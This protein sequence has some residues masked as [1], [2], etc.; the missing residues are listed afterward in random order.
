MSQILSCIIYH[1][2]ESDHITRI[3]KPYGG[4]EKME[5]VKLKLSVVGIGNGGCQVCSHLAKNGHRVFCINSSQKDLDE[6]ILAKNIPSYL[7]GDK[8]GAGRNR[9]T[10]KEF[11][12]I[13]LNKLFSNSVFTNLTDDADIIVVI[14]SM[15]GG[16]GSGTGPL[17]VNRIQ[18]MY[19]NK[20]V[21][22]FGILPKHSES[23][24][25]QFNALDCMKEVSNEKYPMTYMLADLSN[26][27]DCASDEAYQKIAAYA[28]DCMNVLRGDYNSE[29][30]YG[31]IDENDMLTI[32]AETGYMMINRVSNISQKELDKRSIQSMMIDK[33]SHGEAARFQKDRIVRKIGVIINTPSSA[34]DPS[35]NGDFSELQ[36]YTGYPLDTFVNY[37]VCDAP[38]GDAAVIMT[39]MSKPID[40]MTECK[41]I[42]LKAEAAFNSRNTGSI[43]DEMRDLAFIANAKTASREKIFN[44]GLDSASATTIG[45]D[46]PDIF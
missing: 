25:A 16:T 43:E 28:L 45:N 20:A 22:F 36:E 35:R 19:P 5:N 30:P 9:D 7:I 38:K 21:I 27:E 1:R 26:F 46:I 13:E 15:G 32:L 40:R 34:N 44:K 42:A 29:S 8:R 11:M 39:G 12:K 17:L 6:S 33:I 24:Q 23:A 2:D 18:A 41:D 4:N 31:M 10:A 14:A 37:A 3:E